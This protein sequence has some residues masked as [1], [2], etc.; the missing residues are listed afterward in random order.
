MHG[1][2]SSIDLLLKTN[3]SIHKFPKSINLMNICSYCNTAEGYTSVNMLKVQCVQ[4]KSTY[5]IMVNN[6]HIYIQK[7]VCWACSL[8]GCLSKLGRLLRHV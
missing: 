3:A 4:D 5:V 6:A 8:L 1:L 7:N 2:T